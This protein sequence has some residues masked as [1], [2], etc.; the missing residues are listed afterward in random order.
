MRVNCGYAK[1]YEVARAGNNG[2]IYI[3]IC[4]QIGLTGSLKLI[5][6]FPNGL[7]INSDLTN[8]KGVIPDTRQFPE[9]S[10]ADVRTLDILR[11]GLPCFYEQS[12]SIASIVLTRSDSVRFL[13]IGLTQNYVLYRLY[14]I[15]LE[16]QM[17]LL[18]N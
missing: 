5:T 16:V 3:R 10:A 17:V 6:N 9:L 15:Y 1:W 13:F 11:K 12:V 4:V 2:W 7:L 18:W 14:L 8:L